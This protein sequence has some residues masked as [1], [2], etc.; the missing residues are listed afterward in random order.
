MR[1]RSLNRV[2]FFCK[3]VGVLVAGNGR[4]NRLVAEHDGSILNG[5]LIFILPVVISARQIAHDEI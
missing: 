3:S 2:Q 1:Y 4:D 5:R